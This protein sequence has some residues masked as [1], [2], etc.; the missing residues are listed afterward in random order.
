MSFNFSICVQRLYVCNV[1]MLVMCWPHIYYIYI[2]IYNDMCMCE[3]VRTCVVCM[4]MYWRVWWYSEFGFCQMSKSSY[5]MFINFFV[6]W[7]RSSYFFNNLHKHVC[8]PTHEYSYVCVC[9]WVP[10]CICLY[11]FINRNVSS[12][13]IYQFMKWHDSWFNTQHRKI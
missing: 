1:F 8:V 12:K 7:A 6:W 4:Y 11:L 9:V 3:C 5:W 13:P 10:V 2:Y